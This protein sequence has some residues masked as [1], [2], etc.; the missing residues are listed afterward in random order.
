MKEI[1]VVLPEQKT[2]EVITV[3]KGQEI[4]VFTAK[5]KTRFTCWSM[6]GTIGTQDNLVQ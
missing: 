1:D 6:S 2:E 5:P 3:T 4:L